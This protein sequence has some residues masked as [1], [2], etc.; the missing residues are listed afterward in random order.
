MIAQELQNPKTN[1]RFSSFGE[2]VR[3]ISM[4]GYDCMSVPPVEFAWSMEGAFSTKHSLANIPSWFLN[5]LRQI[6]GEFRNVMKYNPNVI[7]SDSRLSSIV[8][9][10]FMGI[11]SIVI[12]NQVK[13]LLSPRLREFRIARLFEK[14]NGEIL[15]MM[16]TLADQILIPDLPP[17]FTI[18]AHTIGNISSV[19][20]KLQYVG[21]TTPKLRIPEEQIS[22]VTRRLDFD[23]SK[24][25][26]FIHLS[27]PIETR[28]PVIRCALEAAKSLPGIQ[29]II[30]EGNPEGDREPKR[31]AGLGWYYEWCP[32]RDEI[33]ALCNLLVLR[34][35]HVS[36]SQAIQFGKPIVSIPIEN[37]GE[38][39][40]NSEKISKI[41]MGVALNARQIS[42]FNIVHAIQNVLNDPKYQK[43]AN[44]LMML[45]KRLDGIDNIVKIVRSYL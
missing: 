38:Q 32:V 3:Y 28:A 39:L 33:F 24:P 30:S 21:F 44:E 45:S 20:R 15:G 40:G 7:L 31:L 2:A 37:H 9:A 34:G 23:R 18:S 43:K 25:I 27:G 17:P 35:G 6:N 42:A 12:L 8:T 13:L 29:Y 36:I 4:H 5:F 22:K 10:K 11:P 41:G 14:M 19:T 26:V 16:W 1:I